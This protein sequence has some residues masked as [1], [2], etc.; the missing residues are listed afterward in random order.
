MIHSASLLSKTDL[1]FRSKTVRER[2]PG[3][4]LGAVLGTYITLI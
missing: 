1:L 4:E 3:R 2:W